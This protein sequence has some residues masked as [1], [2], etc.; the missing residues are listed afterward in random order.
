MTAQ[1]R[2]QPM[3]VGTMT[4]ADVQRGITDL[5]KRLGFTVYH[6]R[7]AIG[8]DRG[9]PDVVGVRDDGKMV[10]VECKGP[11]GRLSDEQQQW[12][13]RFAQVPGCVFSDVVTAGT[14]PVWW[15]YDE[16]LEMIAEA[17]E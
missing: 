3:V 12:L 16:A 2:T 15:G 13:D 14:H 6:T 1:S 11:R 4:E 17:S 5:L 10:V 7:F 9:F 8:S